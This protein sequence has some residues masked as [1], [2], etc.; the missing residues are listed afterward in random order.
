VG[1][2]VIGVRGL[3]KSYGPLEAVRGVDLEVS[4]GEI[5]AFLGPNGAGKTTTVE[6]LE[7]YRHRDS[8]EVEVLGTDPQRA[9][10]A[11]RARI[12]V[13]L[14]SGQLESLLTVRE[15][16]ELYSGY[17]PSARPVGETMELVGLAEQADQRAGR[18]SGGQ[19][20][21]LDVA[22]ALVGDPELLFLDEPT[23]GFDPA[24][25]RGAWEMIAN[26]RALGKTVFLTTHYME[27][28]QALA[29]RV[30][31]IK[32]GHIVA[33]GRPSE[34]G[35]ADV[36]SIR[37]RL[38]PGEDV[39]GL[40]APLSARAS[41]HD[42]RVVVESGSPVRDLATLCGWALE[43]GIDLEA[44]EAVRPTLED[45]YLVLTGDPVVAEAEV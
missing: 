43:R 39:A 33:L 27:E 28:A 17:Y 45:A 38:P 1:G 36:T 6:I 4:E 10:A 12:G 16:L 3:T 13:V 18:L 30:A 25:R 34:L 11:W 22:L 15:S 9:T 5:F 37:F 42:G 44:L 26:L 35:P 2:T 14:Q 7:G 41:V 32:G 19:Q 21:R 31:I 40:P 8:G 29:D 24:A 20:R 23:T